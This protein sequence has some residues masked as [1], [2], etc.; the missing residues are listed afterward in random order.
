MNVI[1]ISNAFLHMRVIASV[2]IMLIGLGPALAQSAFNFAIGSQSYWNIDPL[3]SASLQPGS[4]VEYDPTQVYPYTLTIKTTQFGTQVM[5]GPNADPRILLGVQSQSL[6]YSN[7][8]LWEQGDFA[9]HVIAA[10]A[11]GAGIATD[12][13]RLPKKKVE[14]YV[15]TILFD[16]LY[17]CGCRR[18][19]PGGTAGPTPLEIECCRPSL[20]VRLPSSCSWPAKPLPPPAGRLLAPPSRRGRPGG[21]S[22]LFADRVTGASGSK[23][24]ASGGIIC[25]HCVGPVSMTID[26]GQ[27]TI[28]YSI[29]FGSGWG[30]LTGA[31][32][33]S[34]NTFSSS[35]SGFLNPS[36]NRP[37]VAVAGALSGLIYGPSGTE[38]AGSYEAFGNS[39]PGPIF[40]GVQGAFGAQIPKHQQ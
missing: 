23:E 12:P 9:T 28:V 38:I 40:T 10:G 5:S 39:D 18:D 31:G 2:V 35:L 32:T 29:S 33:L 11:Y 15:G 34:G 17:D 37:N 27:S 8:G 25:Y 14:S 16:G 13:A 6:S 19:Q 30:T 7:F 22:G 24:N 36:A 1:P 4:S 26:F 20:I 21:P 3:V